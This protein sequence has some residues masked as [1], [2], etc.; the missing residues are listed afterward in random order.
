[1]EIYVNRPKLDYQLSK[2]VKT[3]KSTWHLYPNTKDLDNMIKFYMDAMQGVAYLNDNVVTKL[4]C[5][6]DFLTEMGNSLISE[7]HIIFKMEQST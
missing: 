2:G 6:K 1:M 3:M 5:S 4:T 7:E